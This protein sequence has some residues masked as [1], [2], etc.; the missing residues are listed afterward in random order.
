MV[1]SISTALYAILAV[2]CPNT[3]VVKSCLLTARR[4]SP[5]EVLRSPQ[6]RAG[7]RL[8]NLCVDELINFLS[9]VALEL[10]PHK[11]TV[12]CYAPGAIDTPMGAFPLSRNWLQVKI[13][14]H[15]RKCGQGLRAHR[16]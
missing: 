9:F 1:G 11:I 7:T 15:R 5:C 2:D 6:V 16:S 3:Q 12:N 8:V 10:R 13:F 14:D 4:S